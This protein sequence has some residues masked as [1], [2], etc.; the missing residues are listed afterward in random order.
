MGRMIVWAVVC[1]QGGGAGPYLAEIP[2][3]RVNPPFVPGWIAG[4]GDNPC[5]ANHSILNGPTQG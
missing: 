1:W 3:A 4:Q 2:T 5:P